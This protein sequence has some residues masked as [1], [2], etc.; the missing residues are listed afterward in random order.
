MNQQSD[1]THAP[2]IEE[3]VFRTQR[4]SLH[5]AQ[6]HSDAIIRRR[7][8]VWSVRTTL[9]CRENYGFLRGRREFNVQPYRGNSRST[10]REYWEQSSENAYNAV[11]FSSEQPDLETN[12]THPGNTG[13]NEAKWYTT[14]ES[15]L[16]VM[17]LEI[18]TIHLT[19]ASEPANREVSWAVHSEY[20]CRPI[21]I[22]L[23]RSPYDGMRSML[24]AHGSTSRYFGIPT[25]VKHGYLFALQVRK[26]LQTGRLTCSE[27][28]AAL[29]AAFIVQEIHVRGLED[30]CYYYWLPT[31]RIHEV[32]RTEGPQNSNRKCVVPKQLKNTIRNEGGAEASYRT[33]P[34]GYPLSLTGFVTPDAGCRMLMFSGDRY[35][36]V[37]LRN[38][39]TFVE[40]ANVQGRRKRWISEP[41][42]TSSTAYGWRKTGKTK[43][44]YV[45]DYVFT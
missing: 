11:Q 40:R 10:D 44:W 35:G 23:V 13:P 18:P 28:T 34:V 16:I 22:S 5:S 3:L 38:P 26:D 29:L 9:D 33:S 7:C 20:D 8:S 41:R 45:F 1:L 6:H 24:Q 15:I 43:R 32:L 2:P 37:T 12:M 42:S 21:S 31:T 14:N 4:L 30:I 36:M 25:G 19:K 39:C 17:W 27:S